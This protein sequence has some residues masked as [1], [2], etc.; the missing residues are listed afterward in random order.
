MLPNAGATGVNWGRLY[1]QGR[2]KDI[3]VPWSDEEL[4]AIHQLGI[5]VEDVRNGI[6]TK[7][8]AEQPGKPAYETKAQLAEKARA[9]GITFDEAAVTRATLINE[10]ELAEKKAAKSGQDKE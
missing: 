1:E 5:S 3:G 9:L 4:H 7:E 2:C 8:E 6:L 10:I